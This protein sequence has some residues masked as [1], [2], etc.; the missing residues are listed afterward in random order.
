MAPHG[1][2]IRD[3]PSFD[4]YKKN[5]AFWCTLKN[6]MSSLRFCT[7]L[8]LILLVISMCESRLYNPH[9]E[10]R[11]LNRPFRALSSTRTV[12]DFGVR[13]H[14]YRNQNVSESKRLSPGGPD[15][16]HH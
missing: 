6:K 12:Y 10:G 11:N 14:H 3:L 8:I 9:K 5:I 4:P 13:Y 7:W 15:P 16:K 2:Y 1:L